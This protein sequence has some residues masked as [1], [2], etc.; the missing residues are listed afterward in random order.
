MEKKSAVVCCLCAKQVHEDRAW[1][2][3]FGLMQSRLDKCFVK[4]EDLPACAL[5]GPCGRVLRKDGHRTYRLVDTRQR[6]ERQAEQRR[7]RREA[8]V[9]TTFAEKFKI[10]DKKIVAR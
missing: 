5:C 7:Q 9:R 4:A 6:M 8:K 1:V 3:G 2:P 10:Q